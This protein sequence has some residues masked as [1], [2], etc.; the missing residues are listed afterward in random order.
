MGGCGEW[1][2][3]MTLPVDNLLVER[4]ATVHAMCKSSLLINKTAGGSYS[5][6][7]AS[8]MAIFLNGSASGFSVVLPNATTLIASDGATD[9]WFFEIYNP[10]NDTVT[11]KYNDGTPLVTLAQQSVCYAMLGDGTS[12]NGVWYIFQILLSSVASGVINYNIF[13]STPFS[14]GSNTDV[15]ITG[16]TFTPQ[17][18]T[19]AVWFNADAQ[20]TQN[21]SNVNHSLY[22]AGV[23]VPDSIRHTQSVSSN[24]IFQQS[25][26]S[27]INVNGSQTIDTRVSTSQGTLTVN[28]RS[29]LAIRLG[30]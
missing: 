28:G 9:G 8:E 30:T 5:L 13:S 3:N 1:R 18:G 21:N 4:L 25:S 19:Y 23:V 29:I 6:T 12:S 11:I 22:K 14:T 20:C 7:N 26:M 15:V 24:F 27:I 16:F 17:A 10:T 2:N